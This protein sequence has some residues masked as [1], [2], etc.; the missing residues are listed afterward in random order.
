MG[1]YPIQYAKGYEPYVIVSK[2]VYVPYDERFRGYA[3]DKIT[4]LA[5]MGSRNASYHVLTRHFVMEEKHDKPP[6]NL[7]IIDRL[8][9]RYRQCLGEMEK[10]KWP[11][12]SNT[13]RELYKTYLSHRVWHKPT[14]TFHAK[15]D[16]R[17]WLSG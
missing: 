4:Q 5:W 13:T 11:Q 10:G 7:D 17:A 6:A 8:N 1:T 14:G 2:E 16:A 3:R 15:H 9:K 12:M